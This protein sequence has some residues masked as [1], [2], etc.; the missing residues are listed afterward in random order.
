MK[1]EIS[2]KMNRIYIMIACLLANPML[3]ASQ[4]A[5]LSKVSVATVNRV[6]QQLKKALDKNEVAISAYQMLLQTEVP[7]E[8]RAERLKTLVNHA[9]RDATSLQ[10]IQYVDTVC[11][12]TPQ[13]QQ[14][15][16]DPDVNKPM[17][18]LPNATSV[19]VNISNKEDKS[20]AID[21]TPEPDAA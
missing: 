12:L 16:Q 18:N 20:R 19:V 10:A 1:K 3:T 2:Q 7:A 6:N 4:I 17:F 14:T 13:T 5:E 11:R 8:T 21:I 9:D 15:K